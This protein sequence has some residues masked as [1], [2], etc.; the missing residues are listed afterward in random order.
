VKSYEKILS[1]D[2]IITLVQMLNLKELVSKT[3]I[4]RDL[5]D[6]FQTTYLYYN[7]WRSVN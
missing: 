7:H 5:I 2:L 6:V 3:A 1:C 4:V